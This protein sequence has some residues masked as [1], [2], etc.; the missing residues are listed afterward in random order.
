M[1]TW[2]PQKPPF[3]VYKKEVFEKLIKT[4]D[5]IYQIGESDA[6]RN[7]SRKVILADIPT[8]IFQKKLAYIKSCMRKYRKLTGMGR[9]IAGVQI[10]IPERIA[11][12]LLKKTLV[13]IINPVITKRSKTLLTYP[14]ICMSANPLIAPVSRPSWI[15]FSYIDEHGEKH[16]W[17]TKDETIEAKIYN[18]VFQHEIDHMDGMFP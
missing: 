16:Y 3:R 8:P 12:I 17:D 15:E 6:L 2:K 1:T 18:R 5:F 13:I 10:G 4:A 14:E 11:V 9:G 7:P